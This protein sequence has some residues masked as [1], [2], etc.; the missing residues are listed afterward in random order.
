MSVMVNIVKV[1]R[2]CVYACV[3]V[4]VCIHVYVC[5]SVYIKCVVECM[6]IW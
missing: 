2:E 5:G 4:C 6:Y 3:H 1:R